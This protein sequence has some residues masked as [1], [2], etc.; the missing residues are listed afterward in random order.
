MKKL[1]LAI[2]TGLGV[3]YIPFFP[4]TIG[5]LWGVSIYVGLKLITHSLI[6]QLIVILIIFSLG[7]WISGKCESFLQKKDH[8]AIVIDEIAGMLVALTGISCSFYFILLGF[9]F[10]RLFDIVKPFHIEKLQELKSGWG[11]MSDDLA[12]GIL[13][14]L[15]L[16][17]LIS[18]LGW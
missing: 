4:G 6:W 16:R 15:F 12:V 9:I 5:T 17:A 7:V 18:I 10:F 3:G 2:G 8:P 14:N 13:T 11:V 1:I